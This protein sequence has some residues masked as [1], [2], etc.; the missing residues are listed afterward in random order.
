MEIVAAIILGLFIYE[1]KNKPVVTPPKAGYESNM[2]AC[3]K[4]CESGELAHYRKGSLDC[5][6]KEVR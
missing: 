3:A 2:V 1:V 5:Q 4:A 6:C